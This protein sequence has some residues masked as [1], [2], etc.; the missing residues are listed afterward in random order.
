M[1]GR[2]QK[3]ILNAEV[4]LIFYFITLLLA[5]F[6]R[7]IFLDCLGAEFIGLT[8]TLGN[9]LGYLNLAELGITAS[10]GFFLFKPLQTNNR[11]E[12]QDILSLLGYL[13]NW[14]GCI[15]LAGGI[16]ISLFFPLIFEKAELGLDIIYFAYYSFLGSSLIGYF[17]NYRQVLLSADQKN[18]LVAVYFQSANFLKTILQLLLAYTYQNLYVWV[19]I[20][21]IFGIVGCI[22]LNWKINKE[23]PWLQVDKSRGKTLLQQYPEIID[24][25]KQ[26]FIHRIKDFVLIKS[27]ELFIFLFVSLKMVAY[28]GNYMIIISKFISLFNSITGSVGASIG[29]LVAEG[30]KTKMIKVFWEYTTIQHTI[31]ATI[32]FSLYAFIEP[33]IYHW[34]GEDYIMDHRI[35]IMLMFYLYISNSR[36]SVDAFNYAHGLYSD[37]WSAWAELIIN[38]SITIIGGLRWGIIG[39]L[40]GKIV[41]LFAIVVLW[42]PYF[43]F[44]SGFKLPV[45]TYW[46]GVVRNYAISLSTFALSIYAIQFIPINPYHSILNWVGYSALGLSFF[47]I[48]DLSTTALYAKGSKDCYEQIKNILHRN[49]KKKEL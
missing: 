49:K 30:D 17:I 20:E 10:I 7:R 45:S 19:G 11:E 48:I 47:L 6:S 41:S 44:S 21:F 26:V 9:I 5:F 46:K 25:T 8:G 35:L 24:K 14:I 40:L 37:V 16:L 4:N 34:L 13:Y 39:I 28:Y 38:V 15:I 32:C 31:A 43:L 23:Y 2:M 1:S 29:N 18:Y 36:G 12:I 22:I 42:K 3:S 27:D 33:F